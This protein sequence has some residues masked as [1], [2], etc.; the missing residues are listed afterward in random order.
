[1]K[2]NFIVSH[3]SRGIL[4]VIRAKEINS[5]IIALEKC[6]TDNFESDFT[7]A[8]PI[9]SIEYLREKPRTLQLTCEVGEEKLYYEV[10]VEAVLIYE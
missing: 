10:Y 1:M 8:E 6:A 9:E 4:G 5:F 2:T 3:E 7:Y